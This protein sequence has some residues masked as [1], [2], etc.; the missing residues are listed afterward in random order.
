MSYLFYSRAMLSRGKQNIFIQI[1]ST[2]LPRQS[3]QERV[4][5]GGADE[6]RH[7]GVVEAFKY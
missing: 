6:K 5:R 3:R 1:P 4:R 7:V 2:P